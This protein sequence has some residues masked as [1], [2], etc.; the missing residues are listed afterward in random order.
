MLVAIYCRASRIHRHRDGVTLEQQEADCRAHAHAQGWTVVEFYTDASKTAYRDDLSKRDAFQRMLA[1]ARRKKFEA[2][3]VYKLDRFARKPLIAYQAAADLERC[4][5]MVVSATERFDRATVSG[6]LTFGILA[7]V[8]EAQSGMHGERMAAIRL[9]EAQHGRLTGP[10]PVGLERV[11]GVTRPSRH[12]EMIT[13]VFRLYGDGQHS[14]QA[15]VKHLRDA[16]WSMPDGRPLAVFDIKR[17]LHSKAYIGIVTCD[18]RE[19]PAGFPAIIAPDLW[20]RAQAQLTRRRPDRD[21]RGYTC[22][23]DDEALLAG[24]GTCANCGAKLHYQHDR[25]RDYRYYY[26]SGR[27]DGSHCNAPYNYADRL[28]A[29]LVE[30]VR[31]IGSLPHAW[32]VGALD[33]FTQRQRSVK[34]PVDRAH[35]E[36]RLRRL[37]R[38]YG[39]GAYTQEEYE[40]KQQALLS[41]LDAAH[42]EPPAL[43]MDSIETILQRV[44]ECLDDV[45]PLKRRAVIQRLFT[46]VYAR[47][48]EI[49]ALRATRLFAPL[50]AQL[51]DDTRSA[52]LPTYSSTVRIPLILA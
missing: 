11:D 30:V 12:A 46:Q 50:L 36:E 3:L 14:F 42:D 39:D 21:T 13:E 18:G 1:D 7:V 16:G 41:L 44:L 40:E 37:A 8:A 32:F 9:T 35:V 20:E 23:A 31:T 45:S 43:D 22:T 47:H 5:V 19:F 28:E 33:I 6:R 2:V 49:Y 24:L 38:A 15:I 4:G 25:R 34:P 29:Q 27:R 52:Y 48:N 10:I 26:C 17:I 51:S